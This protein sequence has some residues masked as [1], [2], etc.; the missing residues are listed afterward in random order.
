MPTDYD[1]NV[2]INCPFD[3]DYDELFDAVLFS[4]YRCGF[5]PRC[6]LEV[7]NAGDTRIEK[8]IRL[9]LNV[10]LAFMIYQGRS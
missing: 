8:L 3:K 6:A 1:L 9:F 2:F 5:R 7:D 10:K 4:V